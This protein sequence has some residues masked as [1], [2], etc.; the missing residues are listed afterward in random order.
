M[1]I[2]AW[3]YAISLWIN[4]GSFLIVELS[5]DEPQPKPTWVDYCRLAGM[6][7]LG[8]LLWVTVVVLLL[9]RLHSE[10]AEDG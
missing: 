5:Y 8:P 9:A 2:A 10:Q 7:L 3:F 1:I 6:I 4:A